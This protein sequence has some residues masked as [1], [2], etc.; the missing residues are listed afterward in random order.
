MFIE[1]GFEW[2]KPTGFNSM[3]T[4]QSWMFLSSFQAMREKLLTH[5]TINTMAHLGAR[6][7]SEISGE[8]VQTTA[9]VLQGQYFSG[10]KP[11][12]FR[13]V[14][15][16]EEQKQMALSSGQNRFDTTAQDDFKKI[17][18]S[19]VAYWI[20]PSTL[21]AFEKNLSLSSIADPKAGLATGDNTKF[22]R[23]W[24]E[25]SLDNIE[26]HCSDC[27][28]SKELL[29]KWYPCHSGGNYRKWYGNHETIVNWQNDGHEIR[30]FKHTDGRQKS[31][32]QNTCIFL[33]RV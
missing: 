5:R 18:G 21:L 26:F 8:V 1:R 17:P 23:L 16:Q 13:L 10:Y 14:D 31:R 15:G 7:F 29:A 9:F 12:F 4:M 24:F 2:C 11:V 33:S 27:L 30:N 25:V 19:P 6:A 20:K 3:V 32:P 28:Q 22:Q